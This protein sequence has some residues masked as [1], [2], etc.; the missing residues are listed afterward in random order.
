MEGLEISAL[1]YSYV[2]NDNPFK[3]VDSEYFKKEYLYLLK[4][5][6]NLRP[7]EVFVKD[8][9][10][11]VYE[12]TEIVDSVDNDNPYFLQA[13]DITTPFVKTEKLFCVHKSDWERYPKGRIA[14]GE[15]LIE[16]KGKAE[17]VAIVPENMPERTLV[18]GSLYKLSVNNLID[19]YTLLTYLVSK[20]GMSFKERFKTNLLISFISKSDLY[21]IPIPEFPEYI[22]AK[23]RNHYS[24]IFAKSE[25]SK[26]LY[27]SAETYLLEC[28]GM[29]DFAANPEA[30][31]VK[32]LKE[33]FLATGRFDSE[34]Y[35]P[36][37]EDY[38]R[39]VQSYPN[40]YGKVGDFFTP[41]KDN[42]ITT[43]EIC[44]Y[45]EI[46][47]IDVSNGEI[48][49]NDI[50]V[51][52]LPANAKIK[53]KKDDVL[54][55]T[56]RPNRGAVAII[57]REGDDMVASGAFTV[58]R[59]QK[60][61]KKEVLQV[62]LRTGFYKDWLLQANTGCSYPVIKDEDILNLPIPIIR[63][64][65]Q[66]EIAEHIQKSFSLRKE[67]RQLLEDAKLTVERVVEIGGVNR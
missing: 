57:T 38:C 28:L 4:E 21:R 56:V 67:A 65:V 27:S 55:S 33:S 24:L 49:Y 47:N 66:D 10:R 6:K 53:V 5:L 34:Y 62:L 63:K 12:N 43:S 31:N 50:N 52:E 19:K 59:E 8:G 64:E 48:T 54:I 18:S 25:E 37:Y 9:Y 35:L 36:K 39:L 1:K 16:V 41:I 22:Q 51:D 40:G 14:K 32:S 42:F 7:L 60:S 13:T 44:K 23:I 11:V 26:N 17:K 30:Y 45:I 3:R 29:T 61:I 15:L 2:L 58:L 20:Y 46:G